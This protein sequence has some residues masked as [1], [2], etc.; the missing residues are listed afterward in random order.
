MTCLA[1]AVSSQATID[2]IVACALAAPESQF[3]SVFAYAPTPDS[4]IASALPAGFIDRCLDVLEN[5]QQEDGHWVDQHNL[6]QWYP[7]TTI[8]VLLA[9]RRYGRI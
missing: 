3:D 7:M 5:G 1:C 8:N 9:L 2:N 4:P 6:P